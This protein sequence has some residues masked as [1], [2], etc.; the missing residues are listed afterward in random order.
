MHTKCVN[1]EKEN[2]LTTKSG[3]LKTEGAIPL[4]LL[5]KLLKIMKRYYVSVTE[6]LNKV[7]SIDAESEK[8]AV[9]KV[10]DA[11]NNSEIILDSDNFC[12]ETVEA[13]DDQGFY[14]DYEK[15]HG[16]TYQHID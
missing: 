13:E 9:Q 1:L 16:E 8:E 7:V 4:T 3:S 15:N 6:H 10:Q 5:T 2:L 14:I 11:Y 12:G